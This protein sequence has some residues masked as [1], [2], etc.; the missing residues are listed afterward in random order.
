MKY[1]SKGRTNQK[2]QT[3]A[4]ILDTC[5]KLMDKKREIS[6]E[7]VANEAG[8]SRA[9]IYRYYSNIETLMTEASLHI[10]H[11]TPDEI[12]QEVENLS[13]E[14]RILH[15]QKH[16]NQLAQEH[17]VAFRR[18]LSAVLA[19]SITSKVKLRGARRVQSL[20]KVLAPFKNKLDGT[21]YNKLINAASILMGIDPLVVCKDICD[22]DNQ[23]ST[24]TLE[25]AMDMILKGMQ[26]E[27]L[28]KNP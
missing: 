28:N 2:A 17:E 6:L 22:L 9:T 14:D 23:E 11:K 18:Y 21:T 7:D 13:F 19:E 27:N 15:V 8:I 5:K 10:Q 25:W 24:E 1:L 3:K 26:I 4:G 12:L 20:N 16:Y